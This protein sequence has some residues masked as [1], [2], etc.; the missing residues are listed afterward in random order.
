MG[1]DEWGAIVSLREIDCVSTAVSQYA[2]V[3]L[4]LYKKQKKDFGQTGGNF[5]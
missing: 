2:S 1:R 4:I 3:H 5:L